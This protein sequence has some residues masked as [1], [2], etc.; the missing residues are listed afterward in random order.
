[1]KALH[2]AAIVENILLRGHPFESTRTK[3]RVLPNKIHQYSQ[4]VINMY[5][6]G[7]QVPIHVKGD[8]NCLFNSVSVAMQGD[9]KMAREL[10]VRTCIELVLNFEHYKNHPYYKEFRLVSPDLFKACQKCANDRAYSSIFTAKGLSSV[11]G[12]EI[13]SVNPTINGMLDNYARILNT[14]LCPRLQTPQRRYRE[15]VFI[16]WTRMGGPFPH[17]QDQLWLPNHFVPLIGND[18]MSSGGNTSSPI[19]VDTKIVPPFIEMSP[20]KPLSITD[21]E[22]NDSVIKDNSVSASQVKQESTLLEE[23]PSSSKYS[24]QHTTTASINTQSSIF[25]SASQDEK[26]ETST[27]KQFSE[28]VSSIIQENSELVNNSGKGEL[29]G[30]F[31]EIEE[32]CE[33]LQRGSPNSC[34]VPKGIKENTY[35]L[36]TNKDNVYKRKRAKRST[37]E[38]DCGAWLSKSSSTKKT[39]FNFLEQSFKMVNVKNGQYCTRQL[40]DWVPLVPQPHDEDMLVIRRFYSCLKR[41]TEYKKRVTWIE[42]SAKEMGITCM[43]RAV[44]EYLGK[45]PETPSMHGNSEKGSC[46]EYV[47]TS[48]STKSKMIEKVR[49]DQPQNVYSEMVLENSMEAPQDLKQVQNFKQTIAKQQHTPTKYRKN[50]ADDIQTLINMMNKSPYIQEIVQMKNKPPMVILYTEYQLKD[51]KLLP[52][53]SKQIDSWS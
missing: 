30:R 9:E 12:R 49:N 8:G 51:K 13:L 6:V 38:D 18:E 47:R 27:V 28:K 31:L 24:E 11:T 34:T 15:R 5:G 22:N 50:T 16:L 44:V 20:M 45:F 42:K 25:C 3:Q 32:L 37:F 36:I 40:G 35:F 53:S 17:P 29:S 4:C 26:T 39:L 1:M 10:R 14:I 41:Q 33:I 46:S 2:H 21:H 52:Q 43:G 19:S 7:T 48:E 23:A